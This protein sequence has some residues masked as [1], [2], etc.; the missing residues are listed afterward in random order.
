MRYL[1]A[2]SWGHG[3]LL[4]G[5]RSDLARRRDAGSACRGR[6]GPMFDLLYLIVVLVLFAI[7]VA[8]IR[9]FERL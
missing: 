1:R 8:M 6:G 4:I 3:V 2:R 9:F 7:S 5:F